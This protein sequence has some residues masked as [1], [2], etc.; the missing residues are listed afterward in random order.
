[1]KKIRLQTV[2]TDTLGLKTILFTVTSLFVAFTMSG[3]NKREDN[4]TPG[5]KLD[6][7]IGKTEQA[8]A[9]AKHKGEKA[10]TEMQAKTEETFAQAGAVIKKSTE[11]AAAAAKSVASET[12]NK[13]DDMAITTAIAAE[14]MKD[15]EIKLFKI[16]VDT[17]DGAIILSGTVPT[18]AVH[19]RATAI[20]KTFSG[21]QSVDNRLLVKAN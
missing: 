12:I 11:N 15:P 17:K 20:A 21:V 3:C 5:Q 2:P 7:L 19:E 4:Q 1:M 6:S 13:M 10:G 8:V 14:L 9:E 18:Q 16:N